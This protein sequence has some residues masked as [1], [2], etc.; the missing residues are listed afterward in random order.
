MRAR[1]LVP[2]QNST[3]MMVRTKVE[4]PKGTK[5]YP[6]LVPR[7]RRTATTTPPAITGRAKF[8]FRFRL[9]ALR[10][11]ITGPIPVRARRTSPMGMFTLLKKGADTEICSPRNASLIRG[12]ALYADH[13]GTH[14]PFVN[15]LFSFLILVV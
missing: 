14:F 9:V 11:A 3:T 15:I 5:A 4:I 10:Q 12:K 8:R 13:I 7:P 6:C 2:F 1:A